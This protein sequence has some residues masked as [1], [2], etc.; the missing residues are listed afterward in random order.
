M[1]DIPPQTQIVKVI[2]IL[3]QYNIMLKTGSGNVVRCAKDSLYKGTG[4]NTVSILLIIR[5]IL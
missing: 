3:M 4:K 1:I 5:I 2:P